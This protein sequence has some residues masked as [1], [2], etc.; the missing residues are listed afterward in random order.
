[1]RTTERYAHLR[2][3]RLHAMV[4]KIGERIHAAKKDRSSAWLSSGQILCAGNKH[5]KGHANVRQ[6][7]W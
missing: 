7:T 6:L 5:L 1:M 4:D 2:D 3:N